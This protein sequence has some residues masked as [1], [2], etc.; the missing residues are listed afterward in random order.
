MAPPPYKLM[1]DA[2]GA[3]DHGKAES[4]WHQVQ[5]LQVDQGGWLNWGDGDALDAVAPNVHGLQESLS[6]NLNNYRML[7][8]WIARSL[9]PVRSERAVWRWH[10]NS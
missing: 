10:T 5:N 9:A 6:F 1:F 8:G 3:V 2:I 4:L 7:D